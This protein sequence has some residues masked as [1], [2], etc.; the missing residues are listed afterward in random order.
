MLKDKLQKG[1][2]LMELQNDKKYNENLGIKYKVPFSKAFTE[3]SGLSELEEL[4][5]AIRLT[6]MDIANNIGNRENLLVNISAFE[7]RIREIEEIDSSQSQ[8]SELN[9]DVVIKVF[10][11]T[12]VRYYSSEP[13]KVEEKYKREP[14]PNISSTWKKIDFT[15]RTP[16]KHPNSEVLKPK[17]PWW[18]FW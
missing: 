9:D 5:R 4:K 17:K 11:E 18:K 16:Y 10:K 14:I 6:K 8:V 13:P 2:K 1:M 15:G 7:K 12:E 3:S